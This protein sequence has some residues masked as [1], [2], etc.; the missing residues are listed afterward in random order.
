MTHKFLAA[1]TLMMVTTAAAWADSTQGVPHVKSPE[2]EKME[3]QLESTLEDI[4]DFSE[5]QKNEAMRT[6][7]HALDDLEQ[8]MNLVQGEID[9]QWRDLSQDARLGKQEALS[10]LKQEQQELEAAYRA[11]QDAGEENWKA[12]QQ[13]FQESWLAAKRNWQSLVGEEDS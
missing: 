4:G 6:A 13:Q 5:E 9:S 8:R 7:R 3:M 12:A 1:A 10:A 11:M 2:P